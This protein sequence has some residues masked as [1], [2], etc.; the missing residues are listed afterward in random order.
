MVAR[1]FVFGRG[2]SYAGAGFPFLGS[3]IGPGLDQRRNGSADAD[4]GHWANGSCQVVGEHPNAAEGG[5]KN[6]LAEI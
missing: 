4:R 3:G 5:E 2:L 6:R 1:T